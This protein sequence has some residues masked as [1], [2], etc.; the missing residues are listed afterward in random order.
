MRYSAIVCVNSCA[1]IRG[2]DIMLYSSIVHVTCV[3]DS[4]RHGR[5]MYV[6]NCRSSVTYVSTK[7]DRVVC[8][9]CH[10]DGRIVGCRRGWGRLIQGLGAIG[11]CPMRTQLGTYALVRCNFCMIP[12]KCRDITSLSCGVR[13]FNFHV[14]GL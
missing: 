3:H 14:C 4:M 6:F 12:C 5:I 11:C 9:T 10:F 2:H 13:G 7:E 1:G 8:S